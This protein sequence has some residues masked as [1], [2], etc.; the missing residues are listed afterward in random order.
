MASMVCS[1]SS[2]VYGDG[3]NLVLDWYGNGQ[4]LLIEKPL[5]SSVS[6]DMRRN[7]IDCS[8]LGGYRQFLQSDCEPEVT[9]VLRPHGI[10]YREG[11]VP[12]LRSIA[13][14]LTVGEL[15]A[16]INRKLDG[17]E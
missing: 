5:L 6:V 12:D 15:F 10:S 3:D 13:E 16:V 11:K 9:L 7:V 4:V 8:H 17:R 2:L 1:S 14:R